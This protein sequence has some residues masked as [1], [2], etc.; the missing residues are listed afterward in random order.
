MSNKKTKQKNKTNSLGV[1][2]YNDCLLLTSAD[3]FFQYEK[4]MIDAASVNATTERVVTK[5][6]QLNY[7]KTPTNYDDE[8]KHTALHYSPILLQ[9]D[10]RKV[11]D[12]QN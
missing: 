9:Q 2:D 4:N 5:P 1:S 3:F 8:N 7:P 10:Q 11:N 12:K 6:T